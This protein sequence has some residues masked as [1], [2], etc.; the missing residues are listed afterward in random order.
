MA[1][2]VVLIPINPSDAKLMRIM[3][4]KSSPRWMRIAGC[5]VLEKRRLVL[6]KDGLEVSDACPACSSPEAVVRG[7][8]KNVFGGDPRCL[9]TCTACGH[10]TENR[11]LITLEQTQ[12]PL[13]AGFREAF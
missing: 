4:R 9:V 5:L 13:L 6:V 3:V 2:T 11:P 10:V 8:H 1:S 7:F 12:G